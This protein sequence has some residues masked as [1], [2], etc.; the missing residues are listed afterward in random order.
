MLFSGLQVIMN[1][2]KLHRSLGVKCVYVNL[3]LLH[4]ILL[5]GFICTYCRQMASLSLYFHMILISA[6]M[7]KL[8]P[9]KACL[10][11]FFLRFFLVVKIF[12]VFFCSRVKLRK[13]A[14]LLSDC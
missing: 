13:P 4:I 2:R 6:S 11:F 8:V 9:F 12:I 5:A 3:E 1:V 14:H 10:N 7:P